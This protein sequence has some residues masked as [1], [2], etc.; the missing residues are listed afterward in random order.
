[1]NAEQ[2]IDQLKEEVE[3]I[4]LRNK[5]VESDKAWE[6]STMRTAV[7]AVQTYVLIFIFML[8]LRDAH[9]FLNAGVATVGYVVS[10]LTYGALKTWW[11]KK[12]N[13]T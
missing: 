9:P 11:L 13:N 3:K 4:K 10:T 5:R 6:T 12:K 7:I 2:E 8:L 1:M